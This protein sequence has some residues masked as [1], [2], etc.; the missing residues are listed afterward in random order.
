[1]Q[2]LPPSLSSVDPLASARYAARQN[3]LLKCIEIRYQ[4]VL[5]ALVAAGT[6][7]TLGLQLNRDALLVYPLLSLLLG[8]AWAENQME[9]R[10]IEGL[11]ADP[12]IERIEP[13]LGP[14]RRALFEIAPG[15][16]RGVFVVT[17]F[18]AWVLFGLT[19][20]G[21]QLDP[22]HLLV[23][24]GDLV[25]IVLTLVLVFVPHSTGRARTAATPH[26]QG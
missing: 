9:Y 16:T 25:V 23:V 22:G 18:V 15:G 13:D 26:T 4:L 6:F 1:M 17:S 11:L 12:P 14:I 8:A 7:L 19:P 3:R 10:Q 24:G 5:A 2:L 21:W 20:P